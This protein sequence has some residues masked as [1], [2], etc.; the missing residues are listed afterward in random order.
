MGTR[1]LTLATVAA[2]VFSIRRELIGFVSSLL[3]QPQTARIILA[4][5]VAAVA[6]ILTVFG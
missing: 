3:P 6:A 4:P 2:S 5:M 1:P